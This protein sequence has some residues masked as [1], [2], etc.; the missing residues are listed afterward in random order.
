MDSAKGKFH[1]NTLSSIF[2]RR[3]PLTR[4]LFIVNTQV[5]ECVFFNDAS[6][7]E[8]RNRI[9]QIADDVLLGSGRGDTPTSKSGDKDD[10]KK[11]DNKEGRE[12]A[13]SKSQ[14]R[15]ETAEMHGLANIQAERAT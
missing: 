15:A 6:D 7:P 14:P 5:F 12:R 11:G 3:I 10:K 4:I 2:V 13:I 9:F 8:M 1:I